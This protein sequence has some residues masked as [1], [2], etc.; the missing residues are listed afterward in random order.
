MVSTVTIVSSL[1]D[2]DP[3]IVSLIAEMQ[4]EQKKIEVSTKHLNNVSKVIDTI[5]EAVDVGTK[6]AAKFL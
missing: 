4:T 1:N 5:T 6:L 3:Q 2:D